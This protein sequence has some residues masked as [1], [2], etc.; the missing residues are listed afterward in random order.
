MSEILYRR[1]ERDRDRGGREGWSVV[2]D[3]SLSLAVDVSMA[4]VH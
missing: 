1:R 3:D 2:Y 4:V